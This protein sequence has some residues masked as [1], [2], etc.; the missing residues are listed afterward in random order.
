MNF[1]TF[2]IS[3]VKDHAYATLILERHLD[4]FGHVNN[5]QYLALFE[6]ARWEMIT[7]RGYGLKQV[8]ENGIGTVVLECSVRFQRE[9]RLREK[10]QIQTGVKTLRKKI[11]TLRQQILIEDGKTAAEASFTMG[12]FNL[13]ERKLVTPTAEWLFAVTGVNLK[14]QE[15]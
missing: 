4:T 5:A 2:D 8:Q 6:E 3:L 12:C 7:S 13:R 1:S 14:V 15:S 10:I 11:L 9:L